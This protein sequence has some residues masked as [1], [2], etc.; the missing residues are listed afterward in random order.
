MRY[1]YKTNLF[2]VKMPYVCNINNIHGSKRIASIFLIL[3]Y[4]IIFE[5]VVCKWRLCR[6]QYDE[7]IRQLFNRFKSTYASIQRQVVYNILTSKKVVRLNNTLYIT[8]LFWTGKNFSHVNS[9]HF[10][11]LKQSSTL[12]RN[13]YII[14][15]KIRYYVKTS[16]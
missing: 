8:C 10:G 15:L 5:R 13:T 14:F 7:S 6:L 16:C 11:P 2:V 9:E 12:L 1:F 3:K 4:E